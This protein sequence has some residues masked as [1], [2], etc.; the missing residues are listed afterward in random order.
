MLGTQHP[1]V[2][3]FLDEAVKQLGA[4]HRYLSHNVE[5]LEIIG[6]HLGGKEAKREAMLH[7][8]QDWGIV[9]KQ[10]V[11]SFSDLRHIGKI[12]TKDNK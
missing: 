4:K 9:T 11:E 1:T 5:Y 2:H 10:D 12:S 7:L 8:L 6:R 3:A